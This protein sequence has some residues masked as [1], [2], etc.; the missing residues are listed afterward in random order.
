LIAVMPERRT[1]LDACVRW[2]LIALLLFLCAP[3]NADSLSPS[4]Y[5]R[6]LQRALTELKTLEQVDESESPDYQNQLDRTIATVGEAL[7]EH[8][9]VRA[10][11]ELCNVDNSWLHAAL[12]DLKA[13]SSEQ[14]PT[15]L[16]QLIAR[17][18]ALEEQVAYETRAANPDDS[19]T[20][21]KEKL[22][23]ILA[24]PEYANETKGPNA[25]A[26]LLQ[27]FI[28]WIQ[29]FLPERIRPAP[30][31]TGWGNVIVEVAVIILALLVLLYVLKILGPRLRGTRRKRAPKKR[32]ARIVLGERLAP[33][34]TATDL[35]SEAEALARR[36]E[37]RAAIRKAYIALLVELGDRKLITLAQ[38]KT[39]RDYLNATRNIPPLH[40]SM[41]TMTDSFERHWYGLAEAS[42][43]DWQNFRSSYQ[44]ALQTQP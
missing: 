44:A 38:F 15:K 29:Q 25:L 23:G 10:S 9:S 11:D 27:D 34:D 1:A 33:E 32:E 26:R 36:G 39:N 31:H 18:K 28:R 43:N 4:D 8:E 13:S 41:R 35:L 7:P 14:R 21:T 5:Q 19:K 24:R 30:G 2:S 6:N 42:E 17:V 37:V 40:A 20:R 16:T 12:K 3:A 22:E